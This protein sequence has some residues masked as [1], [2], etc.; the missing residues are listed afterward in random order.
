V[1]GIMRWNKLATANELY[2]GRRIMVAP[3]ATA[4]ENDGGDGDGE[5]LSDASLD[6][7]EG[8]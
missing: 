2:V 1:Q 3:A 8:P 4:D 7:P 5:H 6:H